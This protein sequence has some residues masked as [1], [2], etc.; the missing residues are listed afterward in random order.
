DVPWPGGREAPQPGISLLLEARPGRLICRPEHVDRV[1]VREGDVRAALRVEVLHDEIKQV[2]VRA[3]GH[4]EDAEVADVA[5]VHRRRGDLGPG[6]RRAAG[7]RAQ[8]QR[9]SGV[10]VPA[11]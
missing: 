10:Q 1:V 9:L 11:A 3:G 6:P 5:D 7:A 8:I 2:S 4:A